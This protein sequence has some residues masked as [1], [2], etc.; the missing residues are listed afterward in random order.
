MATDSIFLPG[1]SHEQRSLAGHGPQG[2]RE[3]DTTEATKQ[4]KWKINQYFQNYIQG[5]KKDTDNSQN[6]LYPWGDVK[7]SYWWKPPVGWRE[8]GL[9]VTQTWVWTPTCLPAGCPGVSSK[10]DLCFRPSLN[11]VLSDNSVLQVAP[12]AITRPMTRTIGKK[13]LSLPRGTHRPANGPTET[14]MIILTNISEREE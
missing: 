7:S 12:G 8:A 13:T 11:E 2:R 5:I 4:A 6:G 9:N 10:S 14:V 3:L 1:E